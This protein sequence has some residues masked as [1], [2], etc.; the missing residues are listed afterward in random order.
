MSLVSCVAFLMCSPLSP[1]SSLHDRWTWFK[2]WKVTGCIKTKPLYSQQ[3][4]W[5]VTQRSPQVLHALQGQQNKS[6]T[7]TLQFTPIESGA[8]SYCDLVKIF[9]L[10]TEM[11]RLGNELK[12]L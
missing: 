4:W 9:K 8:T 11:P 5:R 12:K 10:L 3:K 7:Y 6:Q 1:L 2:L